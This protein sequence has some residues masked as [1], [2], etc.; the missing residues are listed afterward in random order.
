[1]QIAFY[2]GAF[3]ILSYV[4]SGLTTLMTQWILQRT[5]WP[6]VSSGLML[7]VFMAK[8]CIEVGYLSWVFSLGMTPAGRYWG[9]GFALLGVWFLSTVG[10]AVAIRFFAGKPTARASAIAFCS[11]GVELLCVAPIFC[12]FALMRGAAVAGAIGRGWN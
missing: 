6:P 12:L 4:G 5:T 7:V 11:V 10:V 8:S 2:D 9:S 3:F 1:M